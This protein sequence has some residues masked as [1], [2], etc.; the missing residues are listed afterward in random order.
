M[1]NV[2]ITLTCIHKISYSKRSML[3][4]NLTLNVESTFHTLVTLST[5]K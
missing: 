5:C 2:I 4:S 1:Y 3:T